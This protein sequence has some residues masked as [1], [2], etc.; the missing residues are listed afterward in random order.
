MTK[1]IMG[2]LRLELYTVGI[3]KNKPMYDK[4]V[5]V[6]E[7]ELEV[8]N[9]E[10]VRDMF[11][12]FATECGVPADK[13]EPQFRRMTN[14]TLSDAIIV[15]KELHEW[16]VVSAVLTP[17]EPVIS[18]EEKEIKAIEESEATATQKVF[19]VWRKRL[20]V[21]KGEYARLDSCETRTEQ[22]EQKFW[23][24][25]GAIDTLSAVLTDMQKVRPVNQSALNV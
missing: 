19:R 2:V 8:T 7:I 16:K 10:D 15:T 18:E 14:G 24:L 25:K 12:L 20:D 3:F 5:V 23:Q 11:V 4:R 17:P 13:A 21:L 1:P 22:D 6:E 9:G